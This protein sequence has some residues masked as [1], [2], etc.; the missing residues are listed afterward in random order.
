MLNNFKKA[1]FVDLP[2]EYQVAA[3]I[4]NFGVNE[5]YDLYCNAK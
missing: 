2:E 5:E 3:V 1:V 4:Y